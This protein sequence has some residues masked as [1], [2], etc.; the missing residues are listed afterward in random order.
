MVCVSA[1]MGFRLVPYSSLFA[2]P[3]RGKTR[4]I[5]AA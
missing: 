4:L 5:E 2:C 3:V 1:M